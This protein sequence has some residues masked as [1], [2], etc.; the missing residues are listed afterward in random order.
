MVDVRGCR[1]LVRRLTEVSA[2]HGT[3]LYVRRRFNA[4]LNA[5]R[6]GLRAPA[7][8]RMEAR[9]PM[10]SGLTTKGATGEVATVETP[11]RR[12]ESHTFSLSLAPI[13]PG[14]GTGARY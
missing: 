12:G 10:S 14:P 5:A 3:R 8:G 13:S 1:G 9:C 2:E 11:P 6:V 7:P 4:A